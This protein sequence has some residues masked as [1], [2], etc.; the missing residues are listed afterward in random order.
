MATAGNMWDWVT[1]LPGK[2]VDMIKGLIPDLSLTMPEILGGGTWSLREALGVAAEPMTAA[3]GPSDIGH[4]VINPF[5]GKKW[6]MQERAGM[7]E[8]LGENWRTDNQEGF[9]KMMYDFTREQNAKGIYGGS[10]TGNVY[11]VVNQTNQ[12]KDDGYG[13]YLK[14]QRLEATM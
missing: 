1:D 11:N 4:N 6:T 14:A 10:G 13:D 7:R 12:Y 5:T 2:F 9:L 3:Q 8:D